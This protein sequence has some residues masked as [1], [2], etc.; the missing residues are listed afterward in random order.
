MNPARRTLLFLL[1]AALLSRGV[2]A[3]GPAVPVTPGASPEAVELLRFLHGISGKRTIV[4]QHAAPLVAMTQ[5]G[6]VYKRMGHYP[7]LFGQDF[8]FSEPGTWDGINF[9]QRLVD[10]AIRRHDEGFL[11]VLMWHAARPID[12]EPVTFER[13]V[14]GRLTDAEW[15]DLVTPGTAIN[16]RWKSQ[17]DVVA[18]HLRQ[19]RDAHVP[20]LWRPYHEMNGG[21]FWWGKRPGDNGYRKLYRMLYDRLVNFHHLNNLIWIYGANEIREGVDPYALYYPGADVVD[22]LATDVYHGGF[23]ADYDALTALAAGKPIALAEVG[24]PPTLDILRSEPRWTWFM[25]WGDPVSPAGGPEGLR[26]AHAVYDSPDTLT[27]DRLPWVANPP[28]SVH[29]PVVR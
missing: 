7:A 20:V 29:Y 9:R 14:Q 8:G 22:V 25:V 16:D 17:V 3:G 13:S 1:F 27:W 5:L 2:A 19:L 12:D 26:A 6:L 11:I 4:G 10:E 18:W 21:W 23:K 24:R 15:R 28:P